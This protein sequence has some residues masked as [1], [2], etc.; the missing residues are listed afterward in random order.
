LV[1]FAIWFGVYPKAVLRYMDST[2]DAQ[3]A[4]LTEWTQDVKDP[5]LKESKPPVEP[6]LG[7]QP[8]PHTAPDA[9]P[10]LARSPS[11]N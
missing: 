2:I 6:V 4:T 8:S 10:Q 5:L 9:L 1:V 11:R 7:W 3:V